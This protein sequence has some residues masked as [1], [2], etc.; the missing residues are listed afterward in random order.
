[1]GKSDY[2]TRKEAAAHA[3]VHVNTI[4]N[5]IKEGRLTPYTVRGRF[6]RVDV[7]ELNQLIKPTVVQP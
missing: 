2:L 4:S 5:W 3:N 1:M 6:I 7:D